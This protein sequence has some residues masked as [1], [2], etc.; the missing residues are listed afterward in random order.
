MTAS[1]FIPTTPGQ[2]TFC[3]GEAQD[4]PLFCIEAG[5]PCQLAREQVSELLGCVCD[6][7][8]SGI[9]EEKPQWP[10]AAYY[11]STFAKALLDDAELGMSP[12]R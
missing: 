8:L 12:S 6:L 4:Q 10:W 9:M 1:D 7:T 5:I 2:P 3:Q 11:L